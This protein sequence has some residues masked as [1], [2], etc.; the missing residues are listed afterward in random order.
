MWRCASTLEKGVAG[1]KQGHVVP[2]LVV[3]DTRYNAAVLVTV[4]KN[5][6]RQC[7]REGQSQ[8]GEKFWNIVRVDTAW[9]RPYSQHQTVSSS[10]VKAVLF[11]KK[12]LRLGPGE[13]AIAKDECDPD[14]SQP[15]QRNY[16]VDQ[17]HWIHCSSDLT[18]AGIDLPPSCS[19]SRFQNQTSK[20]IVVASGSH[21]CILKHMDLVDLVEGDEK[22]PAFDLGIASARQ[23]Q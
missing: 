23:G 12:N 22:T 11:G 10:K 9:E 15:W 6:S 20:S 13:S 18:S 8:Y 4:G 14:G 17:W 19:R 7:H 21:I 16:L 3:A 5:V 1:D 2:A